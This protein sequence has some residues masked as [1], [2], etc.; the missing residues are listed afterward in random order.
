MV[1]TTANG[2]PGS[3]AAA[4]GRSAGVV[5][6]VASK[7]HNMSRKPPTE[8]PTTAQLSYRGAWLF[9]LL[10]KSNLVSLSLGLVVSMNSASP[11]EKLTSK[12]ARRNGEHCLKRG[13]AC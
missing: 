9:G 13:R 8:L 11:P 10:K 1:A 2:E 5:N 3:I 12:I 7:G 4:L 6:K